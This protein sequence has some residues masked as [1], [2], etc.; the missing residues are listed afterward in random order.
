MKVAGLGLIKGKFDEEAAAN[1]A[2]AEFENALGAE[3]ERLGKTQSEILLDE[4][5]R[6]IPAQLHSEIAPQLDEKTTAEIKR[7]FKI[8]LLEKAKSRSDQ[9]AEQ[10]SEF[11]KTHFASL[12][13]QEQDAVL[14]VI[15]REL[16]ETLQR[17]IPGDQRERILSIW[18]GRLQEKNIV[19]NEY[20][21]CKKIERAGDGDYFTIQTERGAAKTPVTYKSRRVVLAIGL[22]GSP[23]KLRLPNEETIKVTLEG[24]EQNKILYSLSNPD[25]YRGRDIIIVGGGNS[26][27]EAA[28]DLVAKRDGSNITPRAPEETNRVTLLVRNYLATNVKFGNK[29]QLYQCLDDGLLDVKFDAGIKDLRE[30]EAVI[31]D[32]RNN[33]VIE[34]IPNDFVFALIGGERPDRFLQSIGITISDA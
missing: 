5:S 2:D 28:V 32:P 13:Q 31:M 29:L 25:L 16:A 24:R 30:R 3:L 27:V 21:S 9:S 26:A 34:T 1:P 17:K 12:S 20:E 19:I 4:L 14:K 7:Q 10:W 15:R 8:Y 11:Y 6:E 18:L 23:N 33:K 22:R